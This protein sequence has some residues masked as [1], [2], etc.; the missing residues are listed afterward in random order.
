MGT[1]AAERQA[2]EKLQIN[3]TEESRS[4]SYCEAI[5]G[6][7]FADSYAGLRGAL[8]QRVQSLFTL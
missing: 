5:P 6:L 8:G 7:L 3:N 2:T 1:P 4:G